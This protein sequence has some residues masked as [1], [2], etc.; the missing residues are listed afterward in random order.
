M[1]TLLPDM[2]ERYWQLLIDGDYDALLALFSGTPRIDAPRPGCV[3]G[4][5]AVRAFAVGTHEWL[6]GM[7][8]HVSPVRTTRGELRSV[9]EQELHLHLDDGRDVHLPTAIVAGR[10]EKPLLERISVYHTAWPF[11]GKHELRRPILEVDP[12]IEPPDVVGRYEAA[13]AQGNLRAIMDL[14]EPDAYVREPSGAPYVHRGEDRV[15]DFYLT[16]FGNVG[17][18]VHDVCAFTDD[19]EACAVEYNAMKWGRTVLEPQPGLAVFERG[20][21]GMLLHAVRIYEDVKTPTETEGSPT[22]VS[23]GSTGAV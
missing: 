10:A 12:D 11:E 2:A 20:T 4:V 5:D 22:S 9:A 21:D 1:A 3:E 8:A 19:G 18:V 23:A 6:A 13:L 17:G 14:F 7:R 16:A 15:R